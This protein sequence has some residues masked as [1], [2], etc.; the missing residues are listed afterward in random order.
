MVQV[1]LAIKTLNTKK[2]EIFS[3]F[4]TTSTILD[5]SSIFTVPVLITTMQLHK[6]RNPTNMNNNNSNV[7]GEDSESDPLI[8]SNHHHSVYESSKIRF[9][10]FNI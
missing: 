6:S 4:D 2:L 3:N 8:K 1:F 7:I 10:E 9:D 5:T